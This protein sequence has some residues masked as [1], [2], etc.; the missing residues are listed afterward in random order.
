MFTFYWFINF[1][2]YPIKTIKIMINSYIRQLKLFWDEIFLAKTHNILINNE[3]GK[4]ITFQFSFKKKHVLK[5]KEL[6]IVKIKLCSNMDTQLTVKVKF[7][8]QVNLAQ[9]FQTSQ[10]IKKDFYLYGCLLGDY[11]TLNIAFD[12]TGEVLILRQKNYDF[13]LYVRQYQ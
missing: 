5:P 13:Q 2:F 4:I 3:T 11:T 1:L 12:K 7:I 8:Y 6:K 10:N 9:A